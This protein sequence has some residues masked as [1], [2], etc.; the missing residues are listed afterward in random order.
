MPELPEVDTAAR[1]V[2]ER[3]SGKRIEKVS[4]HWARSIDRPSVEH[5]QSLLPGHVVR[6]V[7]RRGKYIVMHLERNKQRRA[8]L[9]HLRMSGS[10]DVMRMKSPAERHDR[11]IIRFASGEELRFNDP[12]KFGRMYLVENVEAVTGRLGLEPLGGDFTAPRLQEIL[13][14]RSGA[15]KSTLLRQD[16][17]A[18]LG[19]IYVDESLWQAG[20]HPLRRA[21]SLS[22]LECQRLH[23]SIQD[24]LR[25]A[26]RCAGTDN[27]DGVV[28]GGMYE[29]RVYGRHGESCP[30][31]GQQIQRII[32]AQRGTAFCAGCQPLKPG[33][34]K[35]IKGSRRALQKQVRRSS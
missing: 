19:N 20:V 23:T 18:G 12:R 21:C 1:F 10:L 7:T 13:G 25:E 4:V 5:F 22:S 3:L 17:V 11:V 15:I 16:L 35:A 30:R 26:I 27:G 6:S 14:A 24:T 33:G 8:L 32:V 9:V 28:T 29:P 2:C 34:G 31:C